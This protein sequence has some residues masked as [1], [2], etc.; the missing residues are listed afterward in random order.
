MIRG[1]CRGAATPPILLRIGAARNHRQKT[2]G[3][4]PDCQINALTRRGAGNLS[5][6]TGIPEA[7]SIVPD[8]LTAAAFEHVDDLPG[9][10]IH[11][12]S[13][14]LEL[15]TA[16]AATPRRR[17]FDLCDFLCLEQLHGPLPSQVSHAICKVITA[18]WKNLV[19]T[20]T[21]A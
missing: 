17:T 5:R 20:E 7:M 10:D 16:E 18:L 8:A 12:C 3:K 15:F 9:I 14:Q 2:I 4:K 13:D 21:A 6:L 1:R 19:A 11:H